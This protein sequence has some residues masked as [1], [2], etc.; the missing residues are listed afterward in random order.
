MSLTLLTA[1]LLA[2]LTVLLASLGAAVAAEGGRSPGAARE[3]HPQSA[4][5]RQVAGATHVIVNKPAPGRAFGWP[6]NGGIWNWGSEILVM[7]LDCPYK[8]HPGFS[9]HDSDQEHPSA[10]WMTSRSTDGGATWTE[11]RVAFADPRANRASLK[12]SALTTPVDFSNPNTIVNFHW[13]S[14]K[15][16][17]RTYFYYSTDRGRTWQGPFDNIPLFDFKA[18]TG[19]TDYEVTGKQS[20][21][22][23]MSCTEVSDAA[24]IRESSYAILTDNGGVTW[25]KGPRIS[26]DLP[27][28][29]KRHKIEYGSM[30]ST[31]RVDAMTL[32]SAFRSGYTPAKGRRTGWID[33]TRS[34]DNGNTWQVAGDYL[35]EMPTLNSSPPALSRLPSGRLVCSWGWRLPDDGSGPTAIQ[36]RT[37]DDHGTTWGDTL[38]L[39]QDGFDYDI[40]YCR[41]VVRPDGKVVTVYYYRTK[42]DGQSPTYIAATIWDADKAV[43]RPKKITTE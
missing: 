43:D 13:D 8:E 23:Y 20:L 28:C 12:P 3:R 35:M 11:H 18:M 34:T 21:T 6:A 30:P 15:P 41:Q 5:P 4:Q 9:N 25:K 40:G 22:V 31:V 37:S 33:I 38:T 19:R 26:R 27:P 32:V 1:L 16:G 24:C 39:R 14:L 10:R 42:A 17:A 2:P 29:G 7:Y 36:A